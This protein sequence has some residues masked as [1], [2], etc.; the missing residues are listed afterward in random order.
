MIDPSSCKD[1]YIYMHHVVV[2]PH[3]LVI[4]LS[5]IYGNWFLNTIAGLYCIQ[6]PVVDQSNLCEHMGLGEVL[7]TSFYYIYI[8][9][10]C[11]Y[12][13][14]ANAQAFLYI[15]EGFCITL[16]KTF[17]IYIQE[18][19]SICVILSIPSCVHRRVVEGSG[20]GIARCVAHGECA[21]L[22]VAAMQLLLSMA[23]IL[24]LVCRNCEQ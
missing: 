10:E 20:E 14:Q 2:P 16:R 17:P 7:R 22:Q 9:K 13:T 3:K 8:G 24:C 4:R 11:A 15:Q 6:K 12:P 5:Y 1:L 21:M 19:K 18:E 23:G